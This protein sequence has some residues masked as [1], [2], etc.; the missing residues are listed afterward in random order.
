MIT[1]DLVE[2]IRTDCYEQRGDGCDECTNY[3]DCCLN[4][5]FRNNCPDPCC[6][7]KSRKEV[8]KLSMAE[9]AEKLESMEESSLYII[10]AAEKLRELAAREKEL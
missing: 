8:A 4:C 2:K 7:E 1:E 9:L 6:I 3:G 5:E 10:V